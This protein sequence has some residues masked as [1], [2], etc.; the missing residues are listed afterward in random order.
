VDSIEKDV[1]AKVLIYGDSHLSS[2]NY[3]AH[4]NY[5]IETLYYLNKVTELAEKNKVDCLIGTGDLTYGR[6]HTLEYRNK[7][8]QLLQRQF[9]LTHGHRYEIKGNHDKAS[10]GMTEYEYYLNRGMFKG[11]TYMKIGNVNINMVDYEDYEDADVVLGGEDEIN[12][13]ITHGYFCFEDSNM[14][15]YGV[16]VMLDNFDKWYGVD[17]II[18]GHIHQEHMIQGT[19]K[20]SDGEFHDCVVHYLPCLSRPSYHEGSNPEV[21]TVVQLT[22]YSDNT[23]QYDLIDVPLLPLEQSFNLAMKEKRK[24]HA[25]SIKVDVS[26]VVNQLASHKRMVGNPED[27]IMSKTDLPEK[28][29]VKAVKLLKDA[30][31]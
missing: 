12:V 30:T 31:R 9:E 3:G 20:N 8:E 26:D 13:I 24:E 23:M 22:I 21:G 28:Y 5:P 18:C 27:I 6:F 7:V 19:I 17:Y 29:R 2:K 11:S 16:P 14:S 1:L 15:V 25:E 10:Y 4:Q